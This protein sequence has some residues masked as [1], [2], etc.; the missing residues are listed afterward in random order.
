M[1]LV[2]LPPVKNPID[3]ITAKLH[4]AANEFFLQL[5]NIVGGIILLLVAYFLG[6]LFAQL[7]RKGFHQRGL[8]D[9]GGVLASLVFGG[10]MIAAVLIT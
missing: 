1:Q 4:L 10:V 3:Q 7:V 5:P 8:V 6:Q 2:T 9:L